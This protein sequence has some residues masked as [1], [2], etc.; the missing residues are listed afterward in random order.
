M[1]GDHDWMDVAGGFAA[2]EKIEEEKRQ[3]LA[4]A[5]PEQ[6]KADNGSAKVVIVKHAGHHLYLDGYEEFNQVILKEMAD[7]Q[8]REARKEV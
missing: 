4:D 6:R 1:Y 2:K 3:V 5:S 7:V 8:Q